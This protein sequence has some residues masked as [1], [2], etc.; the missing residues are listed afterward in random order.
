M[1][2]MDAVVITGTPGSGKSTIAGKVASRL[3]GSGLI[4][5]NELVRSRHLF[6]SR[7]K[8]GT[9]IVRMKALEAEIGRILK[10]GRGR[11]MILD[12]H[13]L[14]DMQIR[15]ATAIVIREHLPVLRRRLEKIGY[16]ERKVMD[17]LVSEALDYCGEHA[18]L[19]YGRVFELFNTREAPGEIIR[20]IRSGRG[21]QARPDLLPELEALLKQRGLGGI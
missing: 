15:K 16:G 14:C 3:R 20:I 17:N 5:I 21:R 19:N 6:S 8:D 12:G 9:M 7:A 10:G 13:L 2:L 11:T 18:S 4:H 1:I